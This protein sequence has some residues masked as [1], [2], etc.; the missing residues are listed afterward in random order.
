MMLIG[1]LWWKWKLGQWS[2]V[3]WVG[4]VWVDWVWYFWL[5]EEMGMVVR[6]SCTSVS[7]QT[8]F[9]RKP[10]IKTDCTF[11][12]SRCCEVN[13]LQVLSWQIPKFHVKHGLFAMFINMA[14][15]FYLHKNKSSTHQKSS[16]NLLIMVIWK[17]YAFLRMK[18]LFR[19]SYCNIPKSLDLANES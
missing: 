13:L 15:D 19:F 11:I 7:D 9:T 18:W 14:Q 17:A 1:V 8:T 12:F 2:L 6:T 4:W 3:W 5:F 16:V 10:S